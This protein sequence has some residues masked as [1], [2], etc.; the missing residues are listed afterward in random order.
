MVKSEDAP[1]ASP[2]T[3][4]TN[5]IRYHV[6]PFTNLEMHERKGPQIIERGEGIYLVSRDGRRYLDGMSS[7]WCATL[8]YSEHRL[9]EAAS[10]QLALLPYSHTF[11]GRSNPKLIELAERLV[12]IGPGKV[13]KVLFGNSGSEANDT[14]IK[15]A[16]YYNHAK[17]RPEKR[18]I[19][20]RHGGYHGSTWLTAS[21]SG[22][23]LMHRDFQPPV[24]GILFTDLPHHYR[25]AEPG[26]SESSFASRLADNLERLIRSEGPETI[27][28]FIAEPVMG[29]GGVIVPPETYFEKIQSVLRKHDILM[30]ADEVICGFG[31]TGNLFGSTTF[32]MEPDM[33]T[34]AKGLSGAYFPISALLVSDEIYEAMV[35]QSRKI[36]IFSHGLTYS[37]HPVGAA[38][39]LEAL[40]IYE[41][42]DIV[43]NVRQSGAVLQSVLRT[44][45]NHRHVGEVRGVGLMAA[46]EFVADKSTRERFDPN[47]RIGDRIV[48]RAE[49]HGLF[50]RAVGDTIIMAPPL[51]ISEPEVSS[52]VQRLTDAINDM[53]AEFRD[54]D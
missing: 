54:D 35:Q 44:F 29:V 42:R 38:V 4:E 13:S 6:H 11:R 31:R 41:E 50:V 14:A 36:G 43:S 40:R 45:E 32:G 3:E 33:V 1:G 9:L 5:D 18:K 34:L 39:A 46:I 15:L 52:L 2:S 19:I 25:C 49:G 10:A 26:E 16:W 27:A 30:I 22:Q 12:S 53:E 21:L 20:S 51:I 37:G 23:P 24:S 8:G 17:G 48:T 7:L 47:L 28:A